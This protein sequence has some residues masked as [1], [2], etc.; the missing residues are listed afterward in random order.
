MGRR[1]MITQAA[2]L[3]AILISNTAVAEVLTTF[4]GGW[5]SQGV[6]DRLVDSPEISSEMLQAIDDVLAEQ[7]DIRIGHPEFVSGGNQVEL[8][9]LEDANVTV[10]FIHEGASMRN[11]VG[12]F[13]YDIGNRP[14]SLSDVDQEVLFP[15]A[16]FRGSG[17][18]LRMGD[19]VSLGLQPGGTAIGFWLRAD[20]YQVNGAEVGEGRWEVSSIGDHNPEPTAELRA[21][22]V[23]LWE[24]GD[25][26]LVLGIEDYLRTEPTCDHD[27]ND[28][29]FLVT[30]DPPE[31]LDLTELVELP[32]GGD[33]D[34][35]GVPDL[36]DAFPEDPERAEVI[37]MPSVDAREYVACEDQ[38]PLRGD[39]DFNDLVSA[40]RVREVLDAESRVK[41]TSIL[42]EPRARGAAQHNG[43]AVSLPV[44]GS[45]VTV[46]EVLVDDEPV[47]PGTRIVDGGDQCI[48]TLVEDFHQVLPRGDGGHYA[49]TEPGSTGVQGSRIELRLEFA[50]PLSRSVIDEA[51]Y[52]L[53]VYRTDSPGHE[54]HQVDHEPTFRADT[55]LLGTGDDGSDPGSGIYYRDDLGFPWLMRLPVGWQHPLERVELSE[56]YPTFWIWVETGGM[57]STDWYLVHYNDLVWDGGN[58]P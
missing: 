17:G 44:P 12:C 21:H 2:L 27:F 5:N 57:F 1:A 19:T 29:V 48:V 38:W 16:S 53:F 42:L 36:D 6:P 10:T 3:A 49:N 39:Y 20:S 58:D 24:S 30:V 41:E 43:L 13:L 51:P 54:I 45:S 9:L 23:L 22:S 56:A 15:N 35:D 8:R 18:Q 31:A 52:D 37:Y 32:G 11:S 40:Y 47:D 34:G 28:V 26:Q 33:Q 46:L 14:P 7:Q 25:E 55:S 4:V 50:T